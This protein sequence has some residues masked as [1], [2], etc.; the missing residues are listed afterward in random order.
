M[1]IQINTDNNIEGD[2]ALFS[3]LESEVK[4]TLDRF[5]ERI[6]RLTV[7]LSDQDS[8]NKSGPDDKRCV[9]EARLAGLKPTSSSHQAATVEQAVDGAA[10]KLRRAL[11]ST[12]GRLD[13]R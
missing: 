5:S 9:M 11:D 2:E 6:T 1:L 7:H 4:N 13:S 10:R 3:R 12:L 8:G